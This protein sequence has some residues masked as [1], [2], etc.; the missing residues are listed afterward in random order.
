MNSEIID[1]RI[2]T[3]LNNKKRVLTEFGG[4]V[5]CGCVIH[6]YF[7]YNNLLNVDCTYNFDSSGS[8]LPM[9][10][11]LLTY[12]K[13]WFAPYCMP[14]IN[15]ILAIMLLSI[16]CILLISLFAIEGKVIRC[17]FVAF[18]MSFPTVTAT[19]SYSFMSYGYILAFLL[20]IFA[21]MLLF[22]EKIYYSI[23]GA[24]CLSCSLGIYQNYFSVAIVT[25]CI[26]LILKILSGERIRLKQL[27]FY[28]I[29]FVLGFVMYYFITKLFLAIEGVQL[30]PMQGVDNLNRVG[31]GVL[32]NLGN[33]I[34][35]C[36]ATFFNFLTSSAMKGGFTKIL[37]FFML[38]IAVITGALHIYKNKI[39]KNYFEILFLGIIVTVFIPIGS[40]VSLLL[41]PTADLHM[42]TRMYWALLLFLLVLIPVKFGKSILM[43]YMAMGGGGHCC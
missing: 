8:A 43:C 4:G 37:V 11:W 23:L 41:S 10:R 9:G 32:E 27:V 16:C 40:T 25:V 5:F 20:A 22:K 15:S 28:G 39:Y 34:V 19:L 29:T 30:S 38:G 24:I 21:V 31:M 26:V 33:S 13:K 12:V 2:I 17:L 14:W 36:Y 18:V 42:L 6:G 3:Y 1:A 7:I 35:V